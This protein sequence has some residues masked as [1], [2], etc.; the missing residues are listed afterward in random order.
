VVR[1]GTRRKLVPTSTHTLQNAPGRQDMGD[2]RIV[3][4]WGSEDSL[5]LT[6]QEIPLDLR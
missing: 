6:V 1:E 5:R 4:L 2:N 3:Y